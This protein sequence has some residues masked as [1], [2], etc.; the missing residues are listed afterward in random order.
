MKGVLT[1]RWLTVFGMGCPQEGQSLRCQQ[2]LPPDVKAS[3]MQ[4]IKDLLNIVHMGVLLL[5][6]V[7]WLEKISHIE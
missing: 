2:M 3:K 6:E 4:K 7:G 5:F 1:G